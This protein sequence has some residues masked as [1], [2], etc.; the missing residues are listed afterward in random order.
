MSSV[1]L[2]WIIAFLLHSCTSSLFEST[3][4]LDILH[5]STCS[6]DHLNLRW[7]FSNAAFPLSTLL[8]PLWTWDT[9]RN[10]VSPEIVEF[11]VLRP[12]PFKRTAIL[13]HDDPILTAILN[14]RIHSVHIFLDETDWNLDFEFRI[15][16]AYNGECRW[17]AIYSTSM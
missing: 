15:G 10:N 7:T 16:F 2:C 14:E 6:E 8:Y 4:T 12:Y 11:R 3:P 9:F 13:H 5:T 1:A 17:T